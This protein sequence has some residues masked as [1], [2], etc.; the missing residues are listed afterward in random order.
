MVGARFAF[1]VNFKNF[2]RRQAGYHR[3]LFAVTRI[4]TVEKMRGNFPPRVE[5]RLVFRRALKRRSNAYAHT[6]AN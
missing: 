6:L 2:C 4:K 3:N 1:I 5:I